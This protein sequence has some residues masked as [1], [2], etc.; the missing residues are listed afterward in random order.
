MA[1]STAHCLLMQSV[2]A[3]ADSQ[4]QTY[5]RFIAGNVGY[6]AMHYQS[7]KMAHPSFPIFMYSLGSTPVLSNGATV[8][9]WGSPHP[10]CL[11]V[12][13]INH[14]QTR[15]SR[16][17]SL[18]ESLVSEADKLCGQRLER[19]CEYKVQA[20]EKMVAA[21]KRR[22]GP[23]GGEDDGAP[24]EADDEDGKITAFPGTWSLA[25][26]GGTIERARERCA[27]DFCKLR[28]SKHVQKLPTISHDWVARGLKNLNAA[29][30]AMATDS[31]MKG[32]V[33][34]GQGLVHDEIYQLLQDF[35]ILDNP[36]EK[37]SGDGPGSGQTPLAGW[38]NR[39]VQCGKSDHET[40]S[41]GSRD[42]AR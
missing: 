36:N 22:I 25:F 20:Q 39:L 1:V 23:K 35:F 37:K 29:E 11:V 21:K 5:G 40:K 38:F 24:P 32:R 9:M 14:S 7:V 2:G 34:F 15:M 26:L 27:G 16:L 4:W 30:R 6:E 18:S 13:N 3:Y 8:N 17:T 33:W 31:G 12:L 42:D 19:I 41:N 10:L 28:Q